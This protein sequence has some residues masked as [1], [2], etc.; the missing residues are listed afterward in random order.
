MKKT[1][2]RKLAMLLAIAMAVPSVAFASGGGSGPSSAGSDVIST[3]GSVD[4]H[5]VSYSSL[6]KSVAVVHVTIGQRDFSLLVGAT[7][8]LTVSIAPVAATNKS[9]SWSLS[10]PAVATVDENGRVTAVSPALRISK[11]HRQKIRRSM[12]RSRFR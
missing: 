9:V 10:D 8:S 4:K 7:K 1:F 2:R 3:V 12:I 6:P 11:R 5:P